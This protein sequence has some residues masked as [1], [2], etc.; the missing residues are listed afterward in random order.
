MAFQ[1]F[2]STCFLE[3]SL[4]KAS[5]LRF[6]PVQ[7]QQVDTIRWSVENSYCTQL[8]FFGSV[9][10]SSIKATI[11]ILI[12]SILQSYHGD[13]VQ[14]RTENTFKWSFFQTKISSFMIH[15]A[16]ALHNTVL[17]ANL[18]FEFRSSLQ[19]ISLTL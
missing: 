1:M 9:T 3:S 16:V 12:A 14:I 2:T 4:L 13:S 18:A 11:T 19:S 5:K 15:F 17:N 6:C 8:G 10:F 7:I